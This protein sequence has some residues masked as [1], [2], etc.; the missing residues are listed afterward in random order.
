MK[1]QKVFGLIHDTKYG[2]DITTYKTLKGRTKA[3]EDLIKEYTEEFNEDL[4]VDED[5]LSQLDIY[6]ETFEFEMES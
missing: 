1:K 3:Y 5:Y 6:L 2:K 4:P